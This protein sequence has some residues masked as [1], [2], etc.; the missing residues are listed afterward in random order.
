M[1]SVL[2]KSISLARFYSG[3]TYPVQ[4]KDQPPTG[5]FDEATST[6][7]LQFQTAMGIPEEELGFVSVNTMEQLDLMLGIAACPSYGL[8][9]LADEQVTPAISDGAVNVLDSYWNFPIGTEI[10]F[11]ADNITYIGRIE[12]HYH[13]YGGSMTPYGYHH[14]VSV[15]FFSSNDLMSGSDFLKFSEGMTVSQREDYILMEL[16]RKNI[17]SSIFSTWRSVTAVADDHSHNLT[18][19]VLPDYL[20]IGNN[21]DFVRI[22]CAAFTA[23]K[24]AD[25][26]NASVPTTKIVDLIWQQSTNK[27][28]PQPISPSDFMCRN[29]YIEHEN[30][31]IE[32]ELASVEV[33]KRFVGG[34]KKDTVLTNQYETHSNSVAE[35]GWHQLNGV[36]IQPL[37]LGHSC[38]WADYSM[39][40]RL[41]SNFVI[42]DGTKEMLLSD[43]L[44]DE[45][46]AYIISDEG[47]I[48]SPRLPI[49]PRAASTCWKPRHISNF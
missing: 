16:S 49:N 42:L 37:Y 3:V 40:I 6:A 45:V 8:S 23:Q 24:L 20:S 12:L 43:V 36:P 15:F 13:P 19:F 31:L 25:L 11:I 34:D 10:P 32:A 48:R 29:A 1:K 5:A 30:T 17:P 33:D 26:F 9:R 44:A 39:G 46:L 27:I 21:D 7:L 41:V 18:L 14:G 35:Y 38:D 2:K 47:V 28:E 22:P 4:P